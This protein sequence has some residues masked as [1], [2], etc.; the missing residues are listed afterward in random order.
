MLELNAD[1]RGPKPAVDN[2][3]LAGRDNRPLD[4]M[5]DKP[6]MVVPT[7]FLLVGTARQAPESLPGASRP[8]EA[9]PSHRLLGTPL[10]LLNRAWL[11]S[12]HDHMRRVQIRVFTYQRLLVGFDGL[13]LREVG[14]YAV[15]VAMPVNEGAP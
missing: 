2:R 4:R 3:R 1:G 14:P 6:R 15:A 5:E 7:T 12:H 11:G 9:R 8:L 13:L 10:R